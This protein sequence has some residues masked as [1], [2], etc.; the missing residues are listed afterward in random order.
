MKDESTLSSLRRMFDHCAQERE[1]HVVHRAV[2]QVHSKKQTNKEFKLSAKIGAYEMDNI[3]L[4][5]V[6]DVN[7]ILR[8]TWEMMGQPKLN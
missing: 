5:L 6:S 8:P 1:Q 3:I 2:N 7:V 4:D